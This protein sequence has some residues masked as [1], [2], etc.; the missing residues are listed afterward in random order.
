[1]ELESGRPS[2]GAFIGGATGTSATSCAL[3]AGTEFY[4]VIPL[5]QEVFGVEFVSGISLFYPVIPRGR[6]CVVW[7]L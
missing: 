6:R 2:E 7:N 5:G 3:F 1:M 4:P